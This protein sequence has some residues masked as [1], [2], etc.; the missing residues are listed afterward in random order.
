M[1]TLESELADSLAESAYAPAPSR[2]EA[3]AAAALAAVSAMDLDEHTSSTSTAEYGCGS[4][5]SPR[6]AAR[7]LSASPRCNPWAPL[8]GPPSWEGVCFARFSVDGQLAGG[9]G[10]SQLRAQD[11]LRLRRLGEWQPS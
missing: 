9:P 8:P 1:T 3:A 2:L 4:G 5:A 10:R 7:C 6:K 11:S